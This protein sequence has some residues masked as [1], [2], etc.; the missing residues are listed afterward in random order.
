MLN[1]YK[2]EFEE[3]YQRVSLGEKP[4]EVIQDYIPIFENVEGFGV[5][6][7]VSCLYEYARL[8]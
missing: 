4:L 7:I 2:T 5:L 3:M 6:E 1:K 8:R